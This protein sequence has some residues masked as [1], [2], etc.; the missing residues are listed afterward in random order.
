MLHLEE[1]LLTHKYQPRQNLQFLPNCQSKAIGDPSPLE[2]AA[3][4]RLLREL[5]GKHNPVL[6][7]QADS[8]EQY[9]PKSIQR[10]EPVAV[11]VLKEQQAGGVAVHVD[12]EE[13]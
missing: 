5:R 12:C 10:P 11:P 1:T 7:V 3:P 8:E 9:G 13:E 6:F 2:H 4:Q